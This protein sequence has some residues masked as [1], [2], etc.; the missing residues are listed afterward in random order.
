LPR[1]RKFFF[2][3]CLW[4]VGYSYFGGRWDIGARWDTENTDLYG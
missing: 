3:L 2:N 1:G 4:L